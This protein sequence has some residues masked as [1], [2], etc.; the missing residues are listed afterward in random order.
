MARIIFDV[1]GFIVVYFLGYLVGFKTG[2]KTIL[3]QLQ[4][5]TDGILNA[6][7]NI[8]KSNK[9]MEDLDKWKNLMK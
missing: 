3:A 4:D 8:K 9:D 7:D 5:I 1:S 2:V 6:A